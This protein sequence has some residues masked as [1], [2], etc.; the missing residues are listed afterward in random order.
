MPLS[1]SYSRLRDAEP[2]KFSCC[3]DDGE[4]WQNR[5]LIWCREFEDI[6]Q[7]RVMTNALKSVTVS[8][9]L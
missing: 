8:I 6:S 7:Q 1:G 3:A 9:R 2:C 4:R 5:H